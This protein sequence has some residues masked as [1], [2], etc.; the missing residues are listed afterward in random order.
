VAEIIQG[1]FSAIQVRP[2]GDH[3]VIAPD[4]VL[5]GAIGEVTEAIVIGT[6]NQGQ[7]Y[8]A[9]SNPSLAR[10]NLLLDRVKHFIVT[11]ELK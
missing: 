3:D 1:P 9:A 6:D 5:E 10:I 4:H 7:L 8:F 2:D 11:G